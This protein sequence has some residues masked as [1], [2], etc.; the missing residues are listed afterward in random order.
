MLTLHDIFGQDAAIAQLRRSI[1]ADRLPHGLIFAGPVGVGKATTAAALA[2]WFLCEK[3]TEDRPCGKCESCRAFT[4]GMHPDYHIITK[5]LIRY[6]DKTGKS[7]GIDLSIH[8]IRPEI[9]DKAAMKSNMGRGKVF[10]IEQAELM[11]AAAQNALLKTL[12]EPPGRTLLILLTDQPGQLL[13]TIRSRCQTVHFAALDDKIVLQELE[14]RNVA[15]SDATDAMHFA[16][17]SLGLALRWLTDGVI[18]PAKELI[19]Q[20]DQIVLGKPATDL[21]ELF[22][23][24]ADQYAQKQLERDELSSKDQATRE[25]M[26]L[27][28]RLASDHI[29]R[30]FQTESDPEELERGCS[31]IDAIARAEEYIDSNVNIALIFQQLA[32]ALE[33]G[34]PVR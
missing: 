29:R 23:N 22:K 5:E 25:A 2:G 9:V 19:R 31:A 33:T 30:R 3:P 1:L 16:S 8:V 15:K 18:P 26:I 20:L 11:N 21:P 28:L 32:A 12:E 10:I 7:K 4:T 34:A 13:S 27:Y 17:G 14:K 6:H 24:A